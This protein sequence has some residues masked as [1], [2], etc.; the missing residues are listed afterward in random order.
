MY[1]IIRAY[2]ETSIES[3]AAS[4]AVSGLT[5]LLQPFPPALYAPWA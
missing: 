5:T 4:K 1:S 2:K 3:S